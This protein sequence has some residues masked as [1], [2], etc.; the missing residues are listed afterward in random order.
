MISFL[1]ALILAT[2]GSLVPIWKIGGSTD[3][4]KFAPSSYSKF[5]NGCIYVVG[6]SS[7]QDVPYVLPG[8]AD[9]WAGSKPHQDLFCFGLKKLSGPNL[10]YFKVRFQD[11]Q[12]SIPPL[13]NV[14]VNNHFIIKW[15]SPAGGGDDSI[16]GDLS[17]AVG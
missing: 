12:A 3:Q 10:F 6:Q 15:Q 1:T 8:P 4:F 14:S 13:I 2:Q 17:H 7:A 5:D 9:S 11:A 16:N